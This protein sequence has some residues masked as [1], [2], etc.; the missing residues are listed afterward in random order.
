MHDRSTLLESSPRR[1]R[2]R[3]RERAGER[4]RWPVTTPERRPGGGGTGCRWLCLTEREKWVASRGS[5][6]FIYILLI[7]IN[8]ILNY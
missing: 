1:E 3:E 2:E 5:Y 7:I 4:E 8:V 6:P